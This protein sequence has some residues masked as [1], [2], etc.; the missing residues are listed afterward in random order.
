MNILKILKFIFLSQIFVL[1][2][3]PAFS[4]DKTESLRKSIQILGSPISESDRTFLTETISIAKNHFERFFKKV[5]GDIRVFVNTQDNLR[6]G[7]NVVTDAIYFPNIKGLKKSGINSRDVI[8]HEAFHLFVCRTYPMTCPSQIGKDDSK[9]VLQESL[10]DYF[11]QTLDDDNCFGN[12]FYLDQK[13]LRDYDNDLLMSLSDSA[14][15]KGN[16]LTKYLVKHKV[17]LKDLALFVDV[18]RGEDFLISRLQMIHS[19]LAEDLVRDSLFGIDDRVYGVKESN[20]RKYWINKDSE[21]EIELV[22]NTFLKDSLKDLHIEWR[23]KDGQ[24]VKHYEITGKGV[25]A[26]YSVKARHQARPEKVVAT[27]KSGAAIIGYRF[28]YFGSR[29]Y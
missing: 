26:A 18:K 29:S 9:V 24:P 23:G 16:A 12:D 19:G 22:P 15:L 21:I 3:F 17:S 25:G 13:C 14:H 27:L 7:Y 4:A 5:S 11:T 1:A 8:I 10:A 20:S 6:T 28:Y 2:S